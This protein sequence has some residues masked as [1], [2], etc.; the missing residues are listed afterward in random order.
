MLCTLIS[1]L[2]GSLAWPLVGFAAILIFKSSIKELLSRLRRWAFGDHTVDF[3]PPTRDDAQVAEV[4]KLLEERNTTAIHMLLGPWAM[5]LLLALCGKAKWLPFRIY[6]GKD[7]EHAKRRLLQL[8]LAVYEKGKFCITPL[9]LQ[10]VQ[11]QVQLRLDQ[12]IQAQEA[13]QEEK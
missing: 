9:G 7:Y 10:A 2:A 13:T 11:V 8:G 3:S 12:A 4:E 1:S 6:R 5:R